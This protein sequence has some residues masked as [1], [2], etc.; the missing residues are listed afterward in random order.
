MKFRVLRQHQGDKFYNAGD[1]REANE[2]DV[3]HLVKSGV[4]EPLKSKAE[5]KPKNKAVQSAPKNK[6]G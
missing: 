5:P 6:A 3:A 2:G 1:E 4:L